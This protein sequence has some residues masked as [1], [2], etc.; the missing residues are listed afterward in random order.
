MSEDNPTSMKEVV[1]FAEKGFNEIN[2][3]GLNFSAEA[4]FCMQ[5]LQNN[6]Y[7]MG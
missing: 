7:L 6:P 2:P 3:I 5:I 1:K 4:E